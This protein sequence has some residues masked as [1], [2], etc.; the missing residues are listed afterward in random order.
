M[1]KVK[2]ANGPSLVSSGQQRPQ[3]LLDLFL[4]S[5]N[6]SEGEGVG[7]V[8]QIYIY[9]EARPASCY[10]AYRRLYIKRIVGLDNSQH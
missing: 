4:A 5:S 7:Q 10:R 2:F 6:R 8:L 1:H 3:L 9:C